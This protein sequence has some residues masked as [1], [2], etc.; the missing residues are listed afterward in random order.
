M[1]PARPAYNDGMDLRPERH[2]GDILKERNIEIIGADP[3]TRSAAL[4]R[5]LTFRIELAHQRAPMWVSSLSI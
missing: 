1:L 2:I 4:G 3:V 5:S